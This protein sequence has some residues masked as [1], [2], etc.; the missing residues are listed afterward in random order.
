MLS[1][2]KK[3]CLLFFQRKRKLQQFV[4]EK[5]IALPGSISGL[6]S[7]QNLKKLNTYQTSH[8]SSASCLLNSVESAGSFGEKPLLE[9]SLNTFL[10]YDDPILEKQISSESSYMGDTTE[11]SSPCKDTLPLIDS[12]ESVNCSNP[13]SSDN[14]TPQEVPSLNSDETNHISLELDN[15]KKKHLQTPRRSPRLLNLIGDHLERIIVPVGPFFQADVPE[16]TGP[17]NVKDDSESTRWLGTRIWPCEVGKTKINAKDVGKGR[18]D[19]C[20]C[21]SPGSIECIRRHTL[22]KR[23][24]LQCDLGTAFF[25]WKF[26]EMGEQISKSW[27][28][29]Q[30]KK[31]ESLARTKS[32]SNGKGFLK[33]ASKCFPYKCPKSIMNYY[34]NVYIPRRISMQ[35]RLSLKQVDDSDEDEGKDFN[36]L[37]FQKKLEG[38]TSTMRS[39]SDVKRRSSK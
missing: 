33:H 27:T 17:C 29:E 32:S 22:E 38:K 16:W 4:K 34:F 30:Q 14:S 18:P 35:T 6:P 37:G 3:C 12:D 31:F 13:L 2:F 9:C 39:P 10:S 11:W 19:S 24:F 36:Y 23:L 15:S 25:S 26:D 20:S 28:P 8:A 5:L 7:Q 21:I 1:F